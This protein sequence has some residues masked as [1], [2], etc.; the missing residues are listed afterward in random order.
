MG[1]GHAPGSLQ[2]VQGADG[3][4]SAVNP[5][6][7][8]MELVFNDNDTSRMYFQSDGG[9]PASAA[10]ASRPEFHSDNS[11][12][13]DNFME[14]VVLGG[15]GALGGV[16]GGALLGGEA[17][18]GGAAGAEA[19]GAA[20]GGMSA[21]DAATLGGMTEGTGGALSG[22][23]SGGGS[24]W[25][26]LDEFST[27]GDPSDVGTY[28][29]SGIES[30]PAPGG[31][32][33]YNDP[34]YGGDFGSFD[35][36]GNG[37]YTGNG[38]LYNGQSP[39]FWDKLAGYGGKLL[40]PLLAAAGRAGAGGSRPGGS[41]GGMSMGDMAFNSTPFLLSAALA[42]SQRN[43]IN[44]YLDR[45]NSISDRFAGNESP[46]LKSLTD[47]YD[48]ST[49]RGR[50]DLTMRLG[51]RGMT[52]SSFGNMDLGNFDYMR[53]VGRGNMV[54]QAINQS[55]GAQSQLT[56]QAI[57]GVNTRNAGTN[58]LLGAGLNASARLFSP[59]SDPFG[60][61]QHLLRMAGANG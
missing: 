29:T 61:Q 9:M 55:V 12:T 15:L 22:E 57:K 46:Y 43:D 25:D 36:G 4:Y 37:V 20:A 31:D 34:N 41:G 47:P 32:G 60:I 24:M 49:A 14:R 26:W 33:L 11:S 51:D 19:G 59:N 2:I 38:T 21:A 44:P 13:W 1:F 8:Q 30:A 56:D 52:G 35:P 48:M 27:P 40:N 17:A 16:A 39:S 3:S 58:A 42:N 50:G 23:A 10:P 53:D 28:G 18:V 7:G 54:S 6:T 45:L 5:R